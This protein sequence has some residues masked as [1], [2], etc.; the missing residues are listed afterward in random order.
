MKLELNSLKILDNALRKLEDGF[1]ELPEMKFNPN[2]T[3]LN[4][5]MDEVA[6]RMQNN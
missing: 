6:K 3:R 2:P 1:D 5:L 4:S